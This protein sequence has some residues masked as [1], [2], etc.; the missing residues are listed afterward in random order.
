MPDRRS[1][2]NTIHI[3]L[4]CM[5]SIILLL[6]VSD[7]RRVFTK[8]SFR[9]HSTYFHS[10]LPFIPQKKIRIEF[11]ANYPLTTFRI[12]RSAK[13]PIP[14]A[15]GLVK[16][17]AVTSFQLCCMRTDLT[18][19]PRTEM[20]VQIGPRTEMT[21]DRSDQSGCIPSGVKPARVLLRWIN[22]MTLHLYVYKATAFNICASN[23]LS[24]LHKSLI[25][26]ITKNYL[27]ILHRHNSVQCLM[28]IAL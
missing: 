6:C 16:L 23:V 13:Y 28:H 22:A 15:H 25:T 3:C 5:L 12:P 4:R 20:N 18:Q 14:T 8:C 21:E 7:L 27:W 17:L 11:S 26:K 9:W 10:A 1:D 19:S 2:A 24:I